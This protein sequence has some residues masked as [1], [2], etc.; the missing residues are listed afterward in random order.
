VTDD[1]EPT[2]LGLA[3][4]DVCDAAVF[5]TRLVDPLDPT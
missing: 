5:T 2:G 3:P 1:P 4:I